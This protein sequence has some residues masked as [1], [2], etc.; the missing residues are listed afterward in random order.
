MG[1]PLL[2][3][4]KLPRRKELLLFIAQPAFFQVEGRKRISIA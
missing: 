4:L 1:T 3:Q 2:P